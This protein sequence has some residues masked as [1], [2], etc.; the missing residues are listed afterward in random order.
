MRASTDAA[1]RNDAYSAVVRTK[2]CQPTRTIGRI[3]VRLGRRDV[4]CGRSSS[5]TKAIPIAVCAIAVPAAE[6]A[7]PQWKP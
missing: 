5:T 6:P 1:T 3:S 7:I 4:A 2:I